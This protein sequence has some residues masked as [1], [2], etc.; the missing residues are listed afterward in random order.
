MNIVKRMPLAVK[1]PAVM[2]GLTLLTLG[3]TTVLNHFVTSDAI[4]KT[5][6]NGLHGLQVERA[7]AIGRWFEEVET[8]VAT[9]SGSPTVAK[10]VAEFSRSWT[11]LGPD[12]GSRIRGAFS[13]GED[14]KSVV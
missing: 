12:A 8:F 14:R 7:D 3:V 6:K 5:T 9:Q 1:L 2:I 10:A 4:T 11:M 13:D